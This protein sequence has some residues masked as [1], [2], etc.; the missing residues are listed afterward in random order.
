[1]SGYIFLYNFWTLILQICLAKSNNKQCLF[2]KVNDE[3]CFNF[4][5][6]FS[7]S[8]V[9]SYIIFFSMMYFGFMRFWSIFS[10]QD[11]CRTCHDCKSTNVHFTSQRLKCGK[12]HPLSQNFLFIKQTILD[13]WHQNSAKHVNH[14]KLTITLLFYGQL[15]F[16]W[17]LF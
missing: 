4:C 10:L 6:E 1:M 3:M 5:L 16:N 2:M 11:T 13:T 15:I 14:W 9:A 7:I 8:K 17:T 12:D